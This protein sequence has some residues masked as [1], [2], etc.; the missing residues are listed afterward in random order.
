MKHGIKA[1]AEISTRVIFL[2]YA[3]FNRPTW[4]TQPTSAHTH[5]S[6][7]T[8]TPTPP[9]LFT[10]LV[11]NTPLGDMIFPYATTFERRFLIDIIQSW[12]Y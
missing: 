9:M 10:R 11:L 2:K 7:A 6:H 12:I 1:H 5:A 3:K 8:H 4:S